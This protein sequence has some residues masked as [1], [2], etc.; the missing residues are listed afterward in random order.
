MNLGCPV[1]M[2]NGTT[3]NPDQLQVDDILMSDQQKPVSVIAINERQ[4]NIFK[5]TQKGG[6]RLKFNLPGNAKIRL[7]KYDAQIKKF[8]TVEINVDVFKYLSLNQLREYYLYKQEEI[9]FIKTKLPIPP[10]ELGRKSLSDPL[11]SIDFLSISQ[12][13]Y[14]KK[15]YH[16]NKFTFPKDY[17]YAPI[18]DRKLFFCGI[19]DAY[20]FTNQSIKCFQIMASN[21]DYLN[22]IE[23]ISNSL[24]FVTDVKKNKLIIKGNFTAMPLLK[25]AG[26]VSSISKSY[27]QF[28]IKY[29]GKMRYKGICT[30]LN[31]NFLAA[32]GI[33]L[34]SVPAT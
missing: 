31:N 12:K 29:I 34:P 27:Y 33:V 1:L 6:K 13:D 19:I 32:N 22:D 5:L 18:D 7:K 8:L 3:K 25:H 11:N 26:F 17:I 23:R 28:D 9:S 14:L 10:Y 15:F 21:N 16:D 2:Y 20:A 4:Y 24:G 30:N